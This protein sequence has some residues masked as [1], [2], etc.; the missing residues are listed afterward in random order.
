MNDDH[1]WVVAANNFTK[2]S[3][4]AGILLALIGGLGQHFGL[5]L[6]KYSHI[7]N[8]E[9]QIEFQKIYLLDPRWW[10]C[11]CFYSIGL[12]CTFAALYFIQLSCLVPLTVFGIY[13]G[14]RYTSWYMAEKITRK[15]IIS[16]IIVFVG[17]MILLVAE[18]KLNTF[19]KPDTLG[20]T[21]EKLNP[22]SSPLPSLFFFSSILL[23]IAMVL[24]NRVQRFQNIFVSSA[25]PPIFLAI[26]FT[27]GKLLPWQLS[28]VALIP[29]AA[30]IHYTQVTLISYSYF[31]W[32]AIH[33]SLL[34]FFALS[35]GEMQFDEFPDPMFQCIVILFGWLLQV[36]GL[37]VLV[38]DKVSRG[39]YFPDRTQ[40]YTR[41]NSLNYE[42]DS[43]DAGTMSAIFED[44]DSDSEMTDD[45][46][47]SSSKTKSSK[48]LADT[49]QQQA[50]TASP[51]DA[52]V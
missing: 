14:Y 33:H 25:G 35:Y 11:F 43:D 9:K 50:T 23:S 13:S 41:F 17:T 5:A 36:I 29:L 4:Y 46:N 52:S 3:V 49:Q 26:A 19:V 2:P 22:A 30:H 31:T 20:K 16:F 38:N 42:F 45:K 7:K 28:F 47:Q 37:F 1:D 6:M 34:S 27:L 12:M 51:P 48:E 10:I 24:L 18:L 32:I 8:S 15:D 21:L 44:T 39:G 40:Q